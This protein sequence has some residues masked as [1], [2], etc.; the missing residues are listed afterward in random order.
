MGELCNTKFNRFLQWTEVKEK[1]KLKDGGKC[2]WFKIVKSD[3]SKLSG[4]TL[5]AYTGDKSQKMAKHLQI[6]SSSKPNSS[7]VHNQRVSAY[8][9]SLLP[10]GH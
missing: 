1:F 6:H 7:L 5:E 9:W 8:L 4:R 10:K 2:I 3:A